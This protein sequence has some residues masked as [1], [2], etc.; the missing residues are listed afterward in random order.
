MVDPETSCQLSLAMRD[1]E[2]LRLNY[3]VEKLGISDPVK[4]Q[5]AMK[6]PEAFA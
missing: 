1:Y 4:V 6:D 2:S 5:A 3:V